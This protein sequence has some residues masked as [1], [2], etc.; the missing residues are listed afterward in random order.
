MGGD[1]NWPNDNSEIFKTG[2]SIVIPF[3]NL[4]ILEQEHQKNK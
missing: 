3:R 2:K 1:N 4:E